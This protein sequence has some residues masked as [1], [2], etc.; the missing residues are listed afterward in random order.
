M[1]LR[2]YKTNEMLQYVVLGDSLSMSVGTSF[3]SSGFPERYLYF[4]ENILK[5]PIYLNNFAQSG[6]TTEVVLKCIEV[7]FIA[8]KIHQAQMITLTIGRN[9]VIQAADTFIRHKNKK[10][11]ITTLRNCRENMNRIFDQIYKLKQMSHHPFIVRAANIYN[12]LPEID[13]SAY[14]INQFN[15][16]LDT[17]TSLPHV[18]IADIYSIF[19]EK[20][21][22]LLS[23][24][25]LHPNEI[26]YQKIAE[27]IN[28]LGYEPLLKNT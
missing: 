1:S 28:Q 3:F 7:P 13:E 6:A 5:K 8:E 11:F 10:A 14:W 22:D 24:D 15:K 2:N 23:K 25:L 12:P 19:K 16:H 27:A 20:E 9:D 18:K 4:A 17:F 26:G 21:K